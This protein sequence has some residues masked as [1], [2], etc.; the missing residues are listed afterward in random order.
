MLW[1]CVWRASSLWSAKEWEISIWSMFLRRGTF[2][3][4]Y[5]WEPYICG[6]TIV[7]EYSVSYQMELMYIE[8]PSYFHPPLPRWAIVF[9]LPHS[10]SP[11]GF[12]P[13]RLEVVL[14]CIWKMY[15]RTDGSQVVLD[16]WMLISLYSALPIGFGAEPVQHTPENIPSPHHWGG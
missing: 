16:V 3:P 14:E 15:P 4:G 6:L 2:S 9:P 1:M 8:R 11:Q 10:F 7:S 5:V 13:L 12:S